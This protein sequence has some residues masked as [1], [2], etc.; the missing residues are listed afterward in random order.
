MTFDVSPLPLYGHGTG[1][2]PEVLLHIAHVC[3]DV[4]Q[5]VFPD[6]SCV[7]AVE[8]AC[9]DLFYLIIDTRVVKVR[10]PLGSDA[11]E[12]AYHSIMIRSPEWYKQGWEDSKVDTKDIGVHRS[13]GNFRH[14]LKRWLSKC[15]PHCSGHTGGNW[16]VHA[17]DGEIAGR[18]VE[19]L[20][21][22]R[23]ASHVA[24]SCGGTLRVEGEKAEY[25][26]GPCTVQLSM[27]DLGCLTVT[28]KGDDSLAEALATMVRHSRTDQIVLDQ[29]EQSNEDQQ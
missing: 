18:C 9:P 24:T 21:A 19:R 8:P 26:D 3:L 29:Y 22:L 1:D 4:A 23:T 27:P 11:V 5:D 25:D 6:R 16:S 14:D 13:I 28:V 20:L 17:T 10:Y 2:A 7:L 12:L 15:L